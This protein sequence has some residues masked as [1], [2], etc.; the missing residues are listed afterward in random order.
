M[1]F[2]NKHL[3][4]LRKASRKTIVLDKTRYGDAVNHLINNHV[5][6]ITVS[7]RDGEFYYHVTTTEKGK[8]VLYERSD[9]IRR[10]NIAIF[11]SVIALVISFLVAFTPFADWSRAWIESVIQSL[12]SQ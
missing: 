9:A 12:F 3:S 4:I 6:D 5:I 7:E 11:L 2:N 1:N 8:A 10:A